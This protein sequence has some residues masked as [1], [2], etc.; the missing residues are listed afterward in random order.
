MVFKEWTLI[1]AHCLGCATQVLVKG[2]MPFRKGEALIRCP[3]C[4]TE[5]DALQFFSKSAVVTKKA[6]QVLG[7]I[8]KSGKVLDR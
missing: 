7:A 8:E 6:M 2:R 5:L 1:D 4:A 3:K